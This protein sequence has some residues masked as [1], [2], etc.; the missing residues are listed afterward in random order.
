[1][2]PLYFKPSV[3]SFFSKDE[4]I[5]GNE[6]HISYIDLPEII[7]NNS[8]NNIYLSTLQTTDLIKIIQLFYA[9][10]IIFLV[11]ESVVRDREE[12]II[13][14]IF[15]NNITR[16]DYIVAKYFGNL[17]TL[18]IPV[19]ILFVGIS[20]SMLF[21]INTSEFPTIKMLL[22]FLGCLFYISLYLIICLLIS[23]FSSTSASALIRCLVVYIMLSII[24]PSAINYIFD[25]GSEIP[26]Q[27]VM[28]RNISLIYSDLYNDLQ[29][30]EN[31]N[32]PKE[33]HTGFYEGF[34]W[35]T[36]VVGLTDKKTYDYYN[37]KVNYSINLYYEYQKKIE[38][39][40][41]SYTNKLLEINK[42]K[43]FLMTFSPD[44]LLKMYASKICNSD[45]ES[46][47]ILR[48]EVKTYR[49]LFLQYIK[50]KNGFETKFFT[51]IN[52]IDIKE[53]IDEYSEQM[54]EM[55]N[56]KNYPR[57]NLQ[58]LPSFNSKLLT[59]IQF[60]NQFSIFVGLNT[61]LLLVTILLFRNKKGLI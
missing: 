15:C 32:K 3:L 24:Y 40:H 22:L 20:I 53:N 56:K 54:S 60:P 50:N 4:R 35:I 19:I 41:N 36:F 28:N 39:I 10:M 7:N 58:D 31:A 2:V 21:I 43:Q 45:F 52:E 23:I 1:M 44:L 29:N 26:S 37:K 14:L 48:N 61:I 25:E 17:I 49:N 18:T 59:I 47:I 57:I 46:Y 34:S 38:D 33:I 30:F 6:V 12:S 55:Y 13:Q 8:N 11:S 27:E 51:Q 42:R 9:I 5:Q 16:L